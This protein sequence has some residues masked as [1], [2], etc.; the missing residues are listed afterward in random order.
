VDI[1]YD[2]CDLNWGNDPLW[3]VLVEGQ[4]DLTLC[5]GDTHGNAFDAPLITILASYLVNRG[6]ICGDFG[7]CTPKNLNKLFIKNIIDKVK[8]EDKIWNDLYL[9]KFIKVI[10]GKGY[11]IAKAIT[12][13][14]V[15]FYVTNNEAPKMVLSADTV[16]VYGYDSNGK[17]TTDSLDV[18]DYY[19][20]WNPKAAPD[21]YFDK[22]DEKWANDPLWTIYTASNKTLTICDGNTWGSAL[23]API[24]TILSSYLAIKKVKCGEFG[25]CNPKSLNLYIMSSLIRKISEDDSFKAL[26]LGP[27]VRILEPKTTNLADYLKNGYVLFSGF[28]NHKSLP[29]MILTSD[30]VKVSG[31]DSSGKLTEDPLSSVD[32]FSGWSPLK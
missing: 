15:L 25:P 4:K 17:Q 29:K 1:Y 8:D 22:C 11:D 13:G 14:Y 26:G 3:T 28:D 12:E 7:I 2:K 19:S 20:G 16:N 30:N 32:Y 24:I 31:F 5:N 9:G 10:K 18:I 21:S 6:T 27:F 23:D